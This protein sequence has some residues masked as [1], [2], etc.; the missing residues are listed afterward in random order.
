MLFQYVSKNCSFEPIFTMANVQLFSE[1]R[2]QSKNNTSKSKKKPVERSHT[3]CF[4]GFILDFAAK[5]VAF[6]CSR[7]FFD[8]E[9]MKWPFG[10]MKCTQTVHLVQ[11]NA[12]SSYLMNNEQWT[13]NNK[14]PNPQI[15]KSTK[16]GRT[17]C[18]STF[19]LSYFQTIFVTL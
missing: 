8:D 16:N 13:M 17:R 14:F 6:I 4:S 10:C 9:C 5:I 18:V 2:K 7:K 11:P 15:T 3:P 1:T 19:T 12:T